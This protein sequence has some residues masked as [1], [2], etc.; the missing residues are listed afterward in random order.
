VDAAEP[1]IRELLQAVP[2]MPAAVIAERIGW[3]HS[4]TVLRV[5]VAELRPRHGNTDP[6]RHQHRPQAH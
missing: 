2:T 6:H 1:R 4:M 5:R 3:Q